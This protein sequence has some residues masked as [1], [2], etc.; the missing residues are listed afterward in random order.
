MILSANDRCNMIEQTYTKHN[1]VAAIG[2]SGKQN[3]FWWIVRKSVETREEAVVRDRLEKRCDFS[4]SS[5][6]YFSSANI[7][8]LG[9]RVF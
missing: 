6:D 5:F 1:P 7:A 2:M 8:T 9:K 4:L 3:C